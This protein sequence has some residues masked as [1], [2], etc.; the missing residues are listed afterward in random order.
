MTVI[1]SIKDPVAMTLVV[2]SQF[3]A[4]P[5]QVWDVWEDARKLERWWG[6]PTFPAT[7]VRHEFVVDGQSR[8]YMSGPN[9]ER[10]HGWWRIRTID[11]PHRIEFDNGLAGD[12]GEPMPDVDPMPSS[13]SFEV[14]DGGTRMTSV[15]NFTD[16]EQMEKMIEMGMKEGTEQ[17]VGQIDELLSSSN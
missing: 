17:A 14:F 4:T 10:P 1:S 15:A 11:K 6:P 5:E 13:V 2:V 3:D 12:D 8:Y 16:I 9:G 7:F